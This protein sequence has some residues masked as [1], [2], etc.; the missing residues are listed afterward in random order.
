M[1]S[2]T[3]RNPKQ[4]KKL[5]ELSEQDV[6]AARRLLAILATTPVDEITGKSVSH[7]FELQNRARKIL[8]RRKERI[9]IFGS[10]IFGEP[11]WEMLLWLYAMDT[12]ARQSLSR[13]TELSGSS[14]STAVRWIGYLEKKG[15]LTREPHPTD[16]RSA[17]IQLTSLGR[18][19]L[20]RYLSNAVT[21]HE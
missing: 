3:T 4:R 11:A 2:S 10:P 20:E 1:S 13:L 5:V 16:R 6:E 19:D 21:M 8:A 15:W 12:E 9:A 17:F 18:R 14:R 7:A